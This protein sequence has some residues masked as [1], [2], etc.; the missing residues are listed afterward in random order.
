MFASL[1]N[2]PHWALVAI[3]GLHRCAVAAAAIAGRPY[4]DVQRYLAEKPGQL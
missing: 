3:S 2:V 4:P 1:S